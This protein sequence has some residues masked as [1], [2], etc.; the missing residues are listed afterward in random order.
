MGR[1][2]TIPPLR[3][4][5]DYELRVIATDRVVNGFDEVD[6]NLPGEYVFH[7]MVN[8]VVTLMMTKPPK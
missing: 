4:N 7:A 3:E 6:P 5:A 2:E 1:P 8:G